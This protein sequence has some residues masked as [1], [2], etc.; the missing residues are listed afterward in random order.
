MLKFRFLQPS[1]APWIRSLLER[2]DDLTC[3]YGASCLM[4]WGNAKIAEC[5]GLYVPMVDYGSGYGYVR[6]IGGND[7]MPL[8][9]KLIAD[10]KERGIRFRLSGLTPPLRAQMEETGLFTFAEERDYFDYVYSVDSL[11]EL[12]GKKLQAKRNHINRFV[13]H[14]PNWTTE[15]MTRANLP[16][17]ERMTERWYQEH[18]D[19]GFSRNHFA[20]EQHCLK[21]AFDNFED[22]GFDSLLLRAEDEVVAWSMGMRL[23]KNTFDVNFEKAFASMQGAYPLI[24][25]EFTRMVREKYPEIKWMNREDDMGEEGLRKAKLSY[26]PEFLLEKS[27]AYRIGD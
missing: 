15:R 11:A 20:A 12:P 13:E 14:Y 2:T 9:P 17:V 26:H 27:V 10:S 24:N 25:R 1:D 3:E 21:L 22:F 4:M 16:E 23:G 19:H 6:P 5:D 8:I 7:F 18:Y